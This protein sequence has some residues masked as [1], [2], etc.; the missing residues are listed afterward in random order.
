[1][2]ERDT[3]PVRSEYDRLAP[4]YDQR[5]RPYIDATLRA[6]LESISLNGREEVLDVACGTGELERL[7]L[8]RWPDLRITGAD[9]SPGMLQQAKSKNAGKQVT[10]LQA[11]AAS[12]GLPD[13]QFDWVICANSF[14]YFPQP[15]EAL[16]QMRRVLRP[17]GTLVLVD[18]CDDY[19]A[20]KLCSV[21]LRWTDPA[22]HQTYSLYACREMLNA[23]GFEPIAATR[24]RT[25]WVWGLM[26]LV[27]RRSE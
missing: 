25:G 4:H 12:L 23:A 8:E 11:D 18:W 16:R 2:K 10:W 20:C 5:W 26:R 15:L 27:G 21:W 3:A 7:L 9:L 17:E 24:F 1:M 22:F 6:V 13:R 14:H 19:L